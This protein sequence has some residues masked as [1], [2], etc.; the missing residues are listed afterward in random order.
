MSTEPPP[1]A[2]PPPDLIA[3]LTLYLEQSR[4]DPTTLTA[5][6][7]EALAHYRAARYS[8][9]TYL[10]TAQ[11]LRELLA[12]APPGATLRDL[13]PGLIARFAASRPERS[14]ATTNNLLGRVRSCC[15]LAV[16]SGALPVSPFAGR[17]FWRPPAAPGCAAAATHH[18][19][20]AIARVLE[21]LRGRAAAGSWRDRRLYALAAVVCY[22]G[23]RKN[24]ALGMLAADVDLD[25][26]F[27]L[28]RPN[29]FRRLKTR[30]SEAP[31]PC[32]DAL[33]P[34]LRDWLPRL[35]GSECLFPNVHRRATPWMGGSSGL[36]AR[37]CLKAAGERLGVAGLTF[38]SLR[39]SLA[40]HMIGR[41]FSPKQAQQVL[42][43]TTDRTTSRHYIHPDLETL[44]VLMRDFDFAD[45]PAPAPAPDPAKAPART[46]RA[47]RPHVL[48]RRTLRRPAHLAATAPATAAPPPS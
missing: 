37:V 7:D 35:G 13:T 4:P 34:I 27:L 31:V 48:P 23:L 42:R 36:C 41:G 21:D 14:P 25:R 32:P 9:E 47:D 43:H 3:A 12:L 30:G 26:G 28:V 8:R 17:T 29:R 2:P 33:V 19:R 18:P 20:A 11:A 16:R 46:Q 24:E 1:L 44:R 10:K 45:R 15:A 39:A 5:W 6:R 40:T 38:R 22:T